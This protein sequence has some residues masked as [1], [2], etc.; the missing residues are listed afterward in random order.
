LRK[1]A[2]IILMYHRVAEL[3][4][5]PWSLC[6]APSRFAEQLRSLVGARSV[7]SMDTLVRRLVRGELNGREVAISFD[8]GYVDNLTVAK[9]LLEQVSAPATVFLT[10]GRLGASE[11]FWWDEL[12]HMCLG[13]TSAISAR[14]EL[15]GRIVELELA[16]R[17]FPA[18]SAWTWELP[19]GNERERVYLQLWNLLQRVDETTRRECMERL[20]Q[21]L[22]KPAAAP[23]NLPM[24]SEDVP[25]LISGGLISVGGHARTHL[26][27]STLSSSDKRSEIAE[28]KRDIESLTGRPVSGFAYPFGDRDEEAKQLTEQAGYTWA[29][30]THAAALRPRPDLFDLPRLQ[31]L[32]W[33][34]PQL[35]QQLSQLRPAA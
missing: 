6:V 15:A 16:S 33:T 13:G 9:P 19:P 34:G 20:R 28:S 2:P 27:L 35:L 14:V 25:K 18:T 1:P 26:A 7:V 29:V 17:M 3:P 11:E 32:N 31:V 12:A 21:V 8:D 10:S 5:D 23:G 4:Y 24:R 22:G 30:S